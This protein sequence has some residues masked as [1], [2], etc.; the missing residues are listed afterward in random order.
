MSYIITE[1]A[2]EDRNILQE[3]Y[4]EL[5]AIQIPTVW[6]T[7][8]FHSKK[9]GTTHQRGARQTCFG[10]IKSQGH[11]KDS[12]SSSRYPH[13]MPLFERFIGSHS[14]SFQFNS[15][16]LNRNTV[17]KK[18]LDSKNAGESLLVGFGNYTGGQT[19]LHL[20][21]EALEHDISS[22]S[23]IFNGSLIHHESKPFDGIRYS[24]VFFNVA[25]PPRNSVEFP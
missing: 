8:T 6:G 10:K 16:Y 17:C 3:I 24:L 5:E 19:V 4:Q 11:L 1:L 25:E 12:L 22:S 21:S 9:T 20:P 13:I 15:V 18:H 23:I 2:E 14:P 7:H